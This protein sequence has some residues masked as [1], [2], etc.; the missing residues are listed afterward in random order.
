MRK[1]L[2]TMIGIN[3]FLLGILGAYLLFKNIN[4]DQAMTIAASIM[5]GV[6]A[7]GVI[8]CAILYLTDKT[9]LDH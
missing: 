8:V 7:T 9:K 1:A 5:F 2:A 6:G 4:V 3:M